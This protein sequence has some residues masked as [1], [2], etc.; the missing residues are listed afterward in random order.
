MEVILTDIGKRFNTQWIFKGITHTFKS[1]S[2]SAL[3]GNNGSGKSTLLQIIYNFQTFSKGSISFKLSQQILLEE[4]LP[5]QVSLAAPYLDL[6]EE[7]TLAEVL[8]FHFN[9]LPL[10]PSVSLSKAVMEAGLTGQENKYIKYFSSGMK[11]RLKLLLAFNTQNALLLLDEPC[12]NLDD[13]GIEWY[14]TMLANEIGNRTIII[15][16]NQPYEYEGC[17][18]I[19]NVTHFK[20]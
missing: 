13:K 15:A 20:P 11:Q 16:S 8:K 17:A 19:L 5:G 1:G 3:I 14:Q 2:A 4:E 7:F 10:K 12:S 18:N 6:P 9:I